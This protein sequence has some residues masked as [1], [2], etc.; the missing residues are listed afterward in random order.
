ME[1]FSKRPLS[2]PFAIVNYI[3]ICFDNLIKPSIMSCIG[4][5]EL[6]EF[7]EAPH[8]LRSEASSF[9]EIHPHDDMERIDLDDDDDDDDQNQIIIVDR[10]VPGQIRATDLLSD[11][12]TTII[13]GDNLMFDDTTTHSI[14]NSN[15]NVN[16]PPNGGLGVTTTTAAAI[17]GLDTNSSSNIS[18][19][20][21]KS[22][23]VTNSANGAI[24]DVLILANKSKQMYGNNS[25]NAWF[26]LIRIALVAMKS[27][28]LFIHS[29][30]LFWKN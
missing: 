12:T 25:H 7:N 6:D 1:N 18:N 24:G 20:F 26:K 19:N 10:T 28:Y 3:E 11:D 29:L 9:H 14:F 4:M 21:S 5:D 30:I 8:S 15:G 16:R 13:Q 17:A 23:K 27:C 2:M 22:D